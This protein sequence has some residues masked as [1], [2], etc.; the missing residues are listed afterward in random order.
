MFYCVSLIITTQG[1][2]ISAQYTINVAD[3][4]NNAIIFISHLIKKVELK[5]FNIERIK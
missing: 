4:Y 1:L 2:C 5:T 3:N